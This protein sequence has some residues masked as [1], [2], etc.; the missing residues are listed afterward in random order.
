M[1][2]LATCTGVRLPV[3]AGQE[4]AEFVTAQAGQGVPGPEHRRDP[5]PHLGQHPVAVVVAHGVVDLLEAV[6]IEQHH[7]G[8]R[9]VRGRP[10]QGLVGPVVEQARLGRPVSMSW[11]A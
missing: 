3:H 5:G 4:H 1:I 8:G 7:R 11:R 2:R 6:E 10:G 9:A